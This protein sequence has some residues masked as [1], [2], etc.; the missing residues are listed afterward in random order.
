MGRRL[1]DMVER[2]CDLSGIAPALRP[3]RSSLDAGWGDACRPGVGP[4]EIVAWEWRHGFALPEGLKRWLGLSNGLYAD[5]PLIHP[6]SAIGPMVPFARVPGLVVQP[7]SWFELGNPNVETVCLD[8]AYRWDGGDYPVFTSG[9]DESAS[10]PRV[11]APGFDGW[12]LR[13]LAEGGR[14]YWFDEGFVGLGDPWRAHL[15]S[16]PTPALADRLVPLAARVS[17]LLRDRVDE[18]AIAA[19]F[20]ISAFDVEAIARHVQHAAPASAGVGDDP[21]SPG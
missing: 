15:R 21:G 6:L 3:D 17:P 1:A 5:G 16:V 19:R 12:F 20:G 4:A 11:I 14:E 10:P 9:D 8:L 18:R 13:L 2:W 7:E